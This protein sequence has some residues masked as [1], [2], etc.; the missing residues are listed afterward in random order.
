MEFLSGE[1]PQSWCDL[2]S[3]DGILPSYRTFGHLRYGLQTM[4]GRAPISRHEL[5]KAASSQTS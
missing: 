2:G 4:T 5:R 3:N 1:W